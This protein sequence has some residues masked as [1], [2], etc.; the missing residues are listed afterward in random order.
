MSVPITM[1][2]RE[3]D[4]SLKT[5]DAITSGDGSFLVSIRLEKAGSYMI[6]ASYAGGDLYKPSTAGAVVEAKAPTAPPLLSPSTI[7]RF[8]GTSLSS[9]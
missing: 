7:Q 2:V 1:S 8:S 6:T 4:G 3:P 9:S 5:I